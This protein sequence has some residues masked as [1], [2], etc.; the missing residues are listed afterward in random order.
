MLLQVTM[1]T[2]AWVS[3]VIF[4]QGAEGGSRNKTGSRAAEGIHIP[5]DAAACTEEAEATNRAN[6]SI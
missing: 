6:S 2:G 3:K 5:G 1:E 4:W